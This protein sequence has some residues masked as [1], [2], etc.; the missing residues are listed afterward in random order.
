MSVKQESMSQIITKDVSSHPLETAHIIS[1][2]LCRVFVG[3]LGHQTTEEDIRLSLAP[4]GEVVEAVIV[5]SNGK[6]RGF[7]F[8]RFS[9][10]GDAANLINNHPQINIAGS[11]CRIRRAK[12]TAIARHQSRDFQPQR[13]VYLSALPPGTNKLHLTALAEPFGTIRHVRMAKHSVAASNPRSYGF[14]TFATVE[15]AQRFLEFEHTVFGHTIRACMATPRKEG[16][17]GPTGIIGSV[18]QPMLRE[19]L[20]LTHHVEQQRVVDQHPRH[21]DDM[22]SGGHRQHSQPRHHSGH[23]TRD[24]SLDGMPHHDFHG[25]GHPGPR[26]P[27]RTPYGMDAMVMGHQMQHHQHHQQRG[28]FYGQQHQHHHFGPSHH[29]QHQHQQQG[30]S[31]YH[32]QQ[33]H[34]HPHQQQHALSHSLFGSA[35]RHLSPFQE[36]DSRHEMGISQQTMAR[37]IPGGMHH[38]HHQHQQP[39]RG[40]R[41]PV[42][43]PVSTG[44][45]PSQGQ[46]QG[47]DI[48]SSRMMWSS[49]PVSA[50]SS[51]TALDLTSQDEYDRAMPPPGLERQQQQQQQQGFGGFGGMGGFF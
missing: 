21:H 8:I 26:H 12:P 30:Y 37:Y 2:Q 47:I 24:V 7:G 17:G 32:P 16:K 29:S 1:D 20:L 27:H 22:H 39:M 10:P 28:P 9:S 34:H 45:Q 5:R 35:S 3:G 36:Q 11:A 4:F 40:G 13:R 49:A 23:P 41:P 50:L 51:P 46:G 42:G 38:Q 48:S 31:H 33:Q 25:H 43:R 14:V 18:P 6:S 15:E 19:G 44:E